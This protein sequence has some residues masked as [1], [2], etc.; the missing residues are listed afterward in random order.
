[1][2][3]DKS[4]IDAFNNDEDIH[5]ATAANVFGIKLK[6]VTPEQRSHAKIV[7]FGIIYGVSALDW[8][9]KPNQVDQN[10]KK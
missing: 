2:S 7:N 4:M 3:N 6:N 5:T 9:I 1:M 8:V 10:Q